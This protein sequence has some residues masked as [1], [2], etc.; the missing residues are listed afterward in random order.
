MYYEVYFNRRDAGK[1]NVLELEQWVTSLPGAFRRTSKPG[2]MFIVVDDE[3]ARQRWIPQ[4]AEDPH[5]Y[6]DGTSIGIDEKQIWLLL[7]GGEKTKAQV[8]S[9]VLRLLERYDCVIS[10]GTVDI[11]EKVKANVDVLF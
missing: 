7:S 3:R 10:D 9:F 6:G 8:R 2:D 1:L 11:T 5:C 4:Y